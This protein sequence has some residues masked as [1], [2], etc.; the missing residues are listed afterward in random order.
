ME[1]AA[2]APD[3]RALHVRHVSTNDVR[4]GAAIAAYRLHQ[5]LT[6]RGHDSRMYVGKKSSDDAAVVQCEP[7]VRGAGALLRSLRGKRIRRTAARLRAARRP[8]YDL[9]T[10]PA[11]LHGP[12]V[13]GVIPDGDVV[14]LHWVAGFVDYES[15]FPAI[16]LRMP[17][18]WTLHD[19][20]PF[21]GGCHYAMA[22]DRYHATCGRCPMLQS[23]DEADDSRRFW[24]QK[25]RS[26]AAAKRGMHIVA[27]SRWLADCARESA[28]FGELP[29]SVIPYG[30]DVERFAPCDRAAA[31]S[32][33]GVPADARVVLF[34]ADSVEDRRKGFD[35]L[36][37]AL[38]GLA[39]VANVHLLSVGG[40]AVE[41]AG[42]AHTAL[43]EVRDDA[44]MAHAY[45]AAD[46]FVIPTR[47]DNLPNTVLEA[48]ACGTP[49]VGFDVGGLPD[50][51]RPGE[52]GM[53]APVGDVAALRDA[54]RHVLTDDA[55][56]AAFA[57]R[58]RAV[59]EAEYALDVQAAKYEALYGQ[60]V[61]AAT[62]G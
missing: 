39:D 45:A 22:C 12:D 38:D 41:V 31:R 43:G 20:N 3:G 23:D 1:P 33:V 50:M 32:A 16:G 4:G 49:A 17:I 47:A 28:L 6:R 54:V 62:H 59:A 2:N 55:R 8:G 5:G 40:G 61:E 34:V 37:A 9:V 25:S 10:N 27:P 60:L 7:T 35:V 53:L 15:F 57:G 21:T 36:T 11:T 46:V 13:P 19:M 51:I 24:Q 42:V 56:R 58:C 44:R 48:M 26:F 52:T 30:L 14:N 18:V 29:V